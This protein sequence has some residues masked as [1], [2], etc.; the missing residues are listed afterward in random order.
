MLATM[1]VIS[2]MAVGLFIIPC[3]NEV[4]PGRAAHVTEAQSCS[5]GC[6]VCPRVPCLKNRIREL[7]Q[8]GSR[9]LLH[10]CVQGVPV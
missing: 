8:N 5:T 3:C 6:H 1:I 7:R 9:S 2:N 10:V 4:R